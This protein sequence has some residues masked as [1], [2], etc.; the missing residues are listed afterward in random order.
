MRNSW[1]YLSIILLGVFLISSCETSELENGKTKFDKSEVLVPNFSADSSFAYVKTQVQFGPRVPNSEAQLQCAKYLSKKLNDFGLTVIEQK[2]EVMAY[3]GEKLR[4]INI[5]GRYK[6]L[7][8]KRVLLF[9]HW[10]SRHIADKDEI[11]KDL[12]IDGANDGASGVGVLLEIARQ[13]Q[14][15]GPEV[16]IDIVFFDTE[17]YGPPAGFNTPLG[18]E[19]WCLGSQYWG[20]NV[21]MDNFYAMYGIGLDMVGAKGA[22][23]PRDGFSMSKAGWVVKKIWDKA[24]QIGYSDYF[25][26]DQVGGLTDD[27]VFVNR[28]TGIPC[29]DIIN[30]DLIN[31]NFGDFH[32]T[33]KDGMDI[34]DK[35]TLKAVGQTVLDVIYNEI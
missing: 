1:S 5:T 24:N 9:A 27:Y 7:S 12:P 30:I 28:Y 11:D 3:N 29:V 19:F 32:H 25:V 2:G 4:M 16:G 18:K 26:Y 6:P 14:I 8:K 20:K 31:G 15:S 35:N 13:I 17:D 23:F 34:I 33:H 21:P 22:T 10:D